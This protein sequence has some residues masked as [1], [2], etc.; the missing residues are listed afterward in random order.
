[1]QPLRSWSPGPLHLSISSLS[2]NAAAILTLRFLKVPHSLLT[3]PSLCFIFSLYLHV[4]L[5]LIVLA[6]FSSDV[7]SSWK[8]S[9][10]IYLLRSGW[11][12]TSEFSCIRLG[13]YNSITP[14][15]TFRLFLFTVSFIV[16]QSYL[17]VS[18]LCAFDELF[19]QSLFLPHVNVPTCVPKWMRANKYYIVGL[20][21][22]IFLMVIWQPEN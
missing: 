4:C 15:G 1:M 3:S 8:V 7:T 10:T 19:N 9:R 17:M 5:T 18:V 21:K 6:T 16:A 12:L 22:N 11:Y 2:P 20:T 14:N 13:L